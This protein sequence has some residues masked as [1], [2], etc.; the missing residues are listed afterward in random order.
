MTMK[1]VLCLAV[2][3]A[4]GSASYCPTY[5]CDSSLAS[6]VCA[7]FTS[8]QTFKL[9][10]NGCQSGYY[11]SSIATSIWSILLSGT[12]TAGSTYSCLAESTF[13]TT[14]TNTW[15]SMSCGTK[16]AN[17][18]FKNGQTVISCTS[19]T[20]CQLADLTYSDCGCIFKTD[21]SGICEASTSNDQV[22]AG[23][24]N[25]CGASNTITDQDTAIYWVYYVMYWEYSQSTV[26]CMSIFWETQTLRHLYDAYNGAAALEVGVNNG[27]AAFAVGVFGLL[28]LH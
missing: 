6:N 3:I 5:K 22:Y 9:N 4:L 17:K 21:G 28:A 18:N 10:S 12:G 27:A 24:W 19:D 20:D 14:T 25:D 26:S 2:L 13:T 7:S 8:G 23:Y 11:C 16:L 1:T 15:T